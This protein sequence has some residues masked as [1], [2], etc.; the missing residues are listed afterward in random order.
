MM[1]VGDG[2]H[3]DEEGNYIFGGVTIENNLFRNLSGGTALVLGKG[4]VRMRNIT[5]R[6]NVFDTNLAGSAIQISSPQENLVIDHNVFLHQK[7]AIAVYPVGTG[8]PMATPPLPST[9]SIRGN[10][11]SHDGGTVDERLLDVPAGSQIRLSDN[12]FFDAAPPTVSSGKV[13]AGPLLRASDRLDYRPRA[14]SAAILPGADVGAYESSARADAGA[15]WWEVMAD[16]PR[17]IQPGTEGR[18]DVSQSE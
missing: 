2:S 10:I 16:A 5:V 11:F 17:A 18:G 9:I 12:L 6:G 4:K 1:E 7:Q 15:L 8:N 3:A 13:V 14:G